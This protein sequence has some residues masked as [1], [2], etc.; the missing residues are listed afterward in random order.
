MLIFLSVQTTGLEE[1]AKICSVG[2]IINRN[3]NT[4][5][6]KYELINEGRKIPSNASSVH[7]ITSE[8]IQNK[9]SF[10][11]SEIYNI[12]E[13]CNDKKNT[14]IMH[15]A[16]FDLEILQAHDFFWKGKVIDTLRTTKHLIPECEFFS[17]NYLRYELQL[18]KTE[19]TIKKTLGIDDAIISH[20][21]LSDNILIFMLFNYLKDYTDEDAMI[22]L[23]VK[24]V[25]I[26][27]FK[28]GKY[29]NQYIEDIALTDR[30]YLY[31]LLENVT[32]LHED[33][34]YSI[35]YFLGENK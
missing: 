33:L 1:S 12:L 11:S 34:R 19:T 3:Q 31:W 5:T 17:L 13:E 26:Q 8:M 6:T 23:S 30:G 28:F 27:Q 20:N 4:F 16:K 7:N 25:L 15:N 9:S 18:Y 10:F 29:A 2:L 14:L 24:N 21:R 32:D 22:E 35:E